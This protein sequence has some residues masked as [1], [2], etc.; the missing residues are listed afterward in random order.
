[1]IMIMSLKQNLIMIM[2]MITKKSVI[3]C[4]QLW[5]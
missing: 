4:N 5:L 3:D 2:I 1:M